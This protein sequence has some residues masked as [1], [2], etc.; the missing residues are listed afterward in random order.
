PGDA[1]HLADDNVGRPVGRFVHDDQPAGRRGPSRLRCTHESGPIH[2]DFP[3][4]HGQRRARDEPIV[5][6]GGS[7]EEE[8]AARLWPPPPSWTQ[9]R[10]TSLAP[11][12]RVET[13]QSPSSSSASTPATSASSTRRITSIT[14]STSSYG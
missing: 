5:S 13:F 10:P 7:R 11:L 9:A 6:T 12:E 4:T 8:P 1:A 3:R 2:V 14:P